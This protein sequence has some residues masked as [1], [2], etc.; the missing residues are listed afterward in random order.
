MQVSDGSV[1]PTLLDTHLVKS[2]SIRY[3][4]YLRLSVG[5]RRVPSQLFNVALHEASIR[6]LVIAHMAHV[7][8]PLQPL[9][10]PQWPDSAC[11]DRYTL[12]GRI[13]G[14]EQPLR[15][16]FTKRPQFVNTAVD[17]H[18]WERVLFLGG[19]QLVCVI[20]VIRHESVRYVHV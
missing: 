17:I 19:R 13:G 14:L 8:N 6:D 11:T 16:S 2:L 7:N 9:A 10:L 20:L 4:L 5:A 15:V 18:L 1:W 12:H 3:A